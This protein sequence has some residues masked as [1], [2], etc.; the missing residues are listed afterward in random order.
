MTNEKHLKLLRRL[1]KDARKEASR[2]EASKPIEA[3]ALEDEA[4][5]LAH[6]EGALVTMQ[7]FTRDLSTLMRKD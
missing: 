5:M 6:I 4:L 1:A 2:L 3:R 7:R